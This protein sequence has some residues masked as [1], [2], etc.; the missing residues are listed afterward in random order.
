MARLAAGVV[1]VLAA[2]ISGIAASAALYLLV[3]G[4]FALLDAA[5]ASLETTGLWR[6][7]WYFG[8]T[9][10]LLPGAHWTLAAA[11]TY[12]KGRHAMLLV[13]LLTIAMVALALALLF[14][15]GRWQAMFGGLGGPVAIL[16]LLWM[17]MTH[18]GSKA[19]EK[20]TPARSP[21][22]A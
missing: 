4:L 19:L 21:A 5:P 15:G 11:R 22:G 7:A 3:V 20:R 13:K 18:Y 1:I 6:G 17:A 10:G 14:T 2:A 9:F 8:T 12:I 16:I